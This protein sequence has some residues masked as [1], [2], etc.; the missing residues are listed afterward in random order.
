MFFKS[1]IFVPSLMPTSRSA[2][3]G[4]PSWEEGLAGETTQPDTDQS[5]PII[6]KLP[7][8]ERGK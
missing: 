5:T 8:N 1:P 2:E 6:L 4:R 7:Q 3:R